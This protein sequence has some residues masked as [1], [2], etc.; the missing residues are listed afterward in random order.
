V[1]LLILSSGL[2]LGGAETVI[3]HLAQAI[4]A[5][6]FRV[7]LGCV[8]TLGVAGRELARDG[9]DIVCLTDANKQGVDYFTALELRRVVRDRGIQMIHTHT[10]DSLVD[11][12]VCKLM[13]PRLKV[14]HTFHFGNYP[15]IGSRNLWME[16]IFSRGADR[17]VAVGEVQRRQIRSVF[18]FRENQIPMIWN[19]VYPALP[20]TDDSFR[21]RIGAGTRLIVGTVATLIEQKGLRD[22]LSVAKRLQDLAGKLCFV[23]VGDGHLRGELEAIRHELALDDMVIIAGWVPSAATVALPAFDV[24]FQPSLWEAMSVAVLEA[25]AAGKPVVATR[26][27]E[28]PE[29]LEDGVEGLLVDP[30]DIDGMAAALRRL[31]DNP[32]LRQ[33][34]GQAAALTVSRRFTVDQMA[35]TYEQLYL[36]VLR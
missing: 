25:M 17:V 28:N 20:S 19:G 10:T 13:V 1:N 8:K 26:V 12:T 5:R 33:R 3:R 7:T 30:K 22:L 16:R 4:D 31:V 21:T 32:A 23:V 9:A 24:F 15:H 11:A 29:I 14:V 34:L 27:G 35:R 36:D 6:R 18:G 2:G